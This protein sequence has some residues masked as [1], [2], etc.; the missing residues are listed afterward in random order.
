MH[1]STT[2]YITSFLLS[3]SLLT[4][5]ASG[6]ALADWELDNSRSQVNFIS[7][8]NEHIAE[9]HSFD[10]ISGK[11]STEGAL[12]IDIDLSSVNTLIPI[13]NERMQKMLFDVANFRTASF[14]ASVD[15]SLLN[16]PKG[17]QKEVQVDGQLSIKETSVPTSFHVLITSLGNG[18]LSAITLK[19]TILNAGSFN[20]DAGITALQEVAMLNSISK[21]VP[22]TFK[23]V[24][25]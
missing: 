1:K 14:T 4:I 17:E 9:I 3:T 11:I 10:T 20:L 2:R 13:R 16:L 15:K 25:N 8:K 21:T 24:F 22:L 12:S 7:V 19:P 6:S 23:V 5:L 18:Q